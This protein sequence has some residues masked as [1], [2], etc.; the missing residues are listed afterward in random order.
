MA[1]SE[2]WKSNSF[3][4]HSLLD[5]EPWTPF[6]LMTQRAL[7]QAS[8]LAFLLRVLWVLWS[9]DSHSIQLYHQQKQPLFSPNQ[10][11]LWKK[12]L[13]VFESLLHTWYIVNVYVMNEWISWKQIR[14]LLSHSLQE[15]KED[16]KGRIY[17]SA[18]DV[19][20]YWFGGR[21]NMMVFESYVWPVH[22]C[23]ITG[24]RNPPLTEYYW[25]SMKSYWTTFLLWTF[26]S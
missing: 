4:F 12:S 15:K 8:Y 6:W 21:V 19:C 22:H 24:H 17:T 20:E 26:N 18:V 14:L 13:P 11:L 2:T 7:E 5:S 25:I 10:N 9:T 16:C 23:W 1:Q 3:I